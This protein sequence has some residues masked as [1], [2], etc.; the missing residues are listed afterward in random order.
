VIQG[1]LTYHGQVKLGPLAAALA[2]QIASN[3]SARGHEAWFADHQARLTREIGERAPASGRG[4]LCLLGAGNTNDV[5]LD[6]L[7]SRFAEVH[8]VDIDPDAVVRAIGRVAEA[9]RGRV[10][11]HAPLDA[12]GL[13]D[14]LERWAAQ[15]PG[16]EALDGIVAAAVARVTAAL[17]GPFDVVVSCS[18]ITQL[19]LVLVQVVGDRNPRFDEL[20]TALNRAHMRTLGALLA[21]GGVALLVTD[22]TATEIYPPLAHVVA[23]AD[24]GKL[25]SDILAAG[26]FIYAAHP[27]QLSSE[28]RRDPALKQAFAVRFPI[29]PWLWRNGPTQVLL[30][31]AIEIGRR[32][33]AG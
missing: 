20:R 31:Y 24:L 1:G 14:Q 19:Q 8:L 23:D 32:A 5:D 16:P 18:L 27:G 13:H 30:V 17:P 12:S 11:A 3:A 7:A 26:A 25:M 9:R 4:R 33:E 29:G 28:L 10:I 22:L 6:E 2:E 15:P 21:P